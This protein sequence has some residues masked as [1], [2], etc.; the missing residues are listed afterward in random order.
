MGWQYHPLLILFVLGGLV[1]VGIARFCWRYIEQHGSSY[2]VVAIG[3][4]GL[5]NAIWVFA[6]TLKTASTDLALSLLF[7]KLEFIGLLSNTVVANILA[8]SYVGKDHWLTRR[9][10][11]LLSLIPAVLLLFMI[12]NPNQIL[13]VDPVLIPAQGILVFEHEFPPLFSVFLAWLYGS[14]L[15]AILVMAWG[16]KDRHVPLPPAAVGIL[17]LALPLIAAVLKT[18]GVYPPGG[19]GINIAP[20]SSAIGISVFA[21]AIIKYRVFELIP[22]GRSEAVETIREGYILVG[23]EGTIRDSNPA[24]ADLLGYQTANQIQ[25]RP[26]NEVVPSYEAVTETGSVDIERDDVIIAVR[27]SQ[28]TRQNQNAGEVLLL[29]DVTENRHQQRELERLNEHLDE[30]ANTV[31]HD[32]RNPLNVAQMRLELLQEDSDSEHLHAIEQAHDRMEHLIRDVLTLARQGN[33][34]DEQEVVDLAALAD[35]CWQTVET[36]EAAI[37]VTSTQTVRAD[38]SRLRQ[39]LEN[40]F[41]NAIDHAGSDVTVTVGALDEGFYVADDGAGIPANKKESVFDAGYTTA[42][43]GTGFGLQIVEQIVEAH[44]WQITATDSDSGGARF[45]ITGV[46]IVSEE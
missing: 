10:V 12:V 30:F 36:A 17:A 15:A 23:P 38:R 25:N 33:S 28:V 40:L 46:E 37:V 44:G 11:G 39:L 5:N 20:A 34:I 27:R 18:T 35:G 24:A 2:L 4:L 8:L 7:Y 29:H 41:R 3:L 1:S 21:V 26:V 9:N 31:S 6:A 42:P 16:M 45:E 32:L 14:T 19:D 13:I 22:I 43:D